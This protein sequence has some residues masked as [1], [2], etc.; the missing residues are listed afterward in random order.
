MDDDSLEVQCWEGRSWES[1]RAWRVVDRLEM[2][3]LVTR[4]LEFRDR[5]LS[6]WCLSIRY[7]DMEI[8]RACFVPLE[9]CIK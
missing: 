7:Y 9:Q 1:C 5:V 3:T 6:W 4:L 2:M 8:G